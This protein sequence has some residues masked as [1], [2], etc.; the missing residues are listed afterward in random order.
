MSSITVAAL[1]LNSTPLVSGLIDEVAVT[2]GCQGLQHSA[3]DT[4]GVITVKLSHLPH[5]TL[6]HVSL[7]D[8][9]E[10]PPQQAGKPEQRI[11]EDVEGTGQIDN[12]IFLL[13]GQSQTAD[14]V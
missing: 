4:I 14:P 3:P 11:T 13:A 6:D 8:T 9:R 2:D 5:D 7:P 12:D 1:E 10:D